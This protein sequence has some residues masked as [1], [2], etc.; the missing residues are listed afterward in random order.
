MDSGGTDNFILIS[1]LKE[2][3][4][5][6]KR[7]LQQRDQT[8]LEKERKVAASTHQGRLIDPETLQPG[9]TVV[10]EFKMHSPLSSQTPRA[11]AKA[12]GLKCCYTVVLLDSSPVV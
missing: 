6:M 12:V 2:E 1:Q 8:I 11:Q 5:S 4:M 10:P 7:M 3:V 9:G